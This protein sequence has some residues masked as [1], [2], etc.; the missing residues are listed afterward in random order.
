[1]RIITTAFYCCVLLLLA[2]K[3][4]AQS[5]SI[6]LTNLGAFREPGANWVIAGDIMTDYAGSIKTRQVNGTGVLMNYF[7]AK[8]KSHLV[9]KEEFG[10]L[11]LELEFMMFKGSNSGVYLQGRYEIQLLDSWK[12]LNPGWGDV[13]AIYARQ[14][15]VEGTPPGTNVAKA[16]G[17]WQKLEIR[18]RAPRFNEK[19][20]KIQNARFELVRLNG[21]TIIREVDVTGCTT[22]CQ[23]PE[24][25][26][27]GPIVFQGDHG[28]V[29]FRNIKYG[30][31]QEHDRVSGDPLIITPG[32]KP[33]I[34]KT[35]LRH[36]D[37]TLTHVL[38]VGTANE[39]N[40]SYDL[41][42]GS[43]IQFWRGKYLDVGPAWVSRGFSQT[44]VPLGAVTTLAN[45]P[46]VAN[47]DNSNGAWP[48]TLD[49]D[50]MHNKGYAL[51]E[52]GY[53][54]FS[55]SYNNIDIADKI[56]FLTSGDGI[57]RTLTVSG[58]TADSY[59]RFAFGKKIE[60][61]NDGLYLIDDKSYYLQ[62]DKKLKPIVR[63]VGEGYEL[64]VKYNGS[65][66]SYNL[67]W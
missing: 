67:I 15:G 37:S 8:N 34:T 18:F 10:D 22:S 16:P 58:A 36:R 20:E 11:D 6:D 57:S 25:K 1:M 26:P 47:L 53:P 54:T 32:V 13:G 44:G 41:K 46:V 51:D 42:Q 30:K 49:F 23:F 62:L 5:Q 33:E 17:L 4:R 35:F 63:Q 40:Y 7:T 50:A 12:K 27:T 60:K 65:P 24:E 38:S 52:N 39:V 45:G 21:F 66:V 19:G 61:L 55:Y 56:E 28:A 48:G 2:G 3:T 59:C 64:L 9:T 43:I 31:L 14:G 29:A